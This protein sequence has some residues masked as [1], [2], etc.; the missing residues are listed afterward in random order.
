MHVHPLAVRIAHGVNA[1]AL[2][3]MAMSGWGIYN[4]SPLFR[5]S[6]PAWATLGGW[7]GGAIA[8]H[9]AAM[10]LLVGNGLFYVTYGLL[11]G[12]FRRH[13]LPLSGHEIARDAVL[14]LRGR[15]SHQ[16][17]AYNA[18]QRLFYVAVLQ[19]GGLVV[20]SGLA[21]WKPVQFARLTE[22]FGGFDTA[23]LVH[24]IAMAG[25]MGFVVIHLAMVIIV[26]R[27]LLPMVTGRAHR[28]ATNSHEF[29]PETS[30]ARAR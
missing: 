18:V 28:A 4:A 2:T 1:F 7:L 22:L 24:F 27:T 10:W 30:E 29:K 13:F 25:I 20:A 8:W 16:A 26:P 21:I 14:A 5:F 19:L 17:G 12:H 6:F 3:C 9:F 23:R 15:L 11:S